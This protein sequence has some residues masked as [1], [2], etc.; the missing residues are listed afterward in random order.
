M[1]NYTALFDQGEGIQLTPHVGCAVHQL[2]PL[3][4]WLT[5]LSD[6]EWMDWEH[7]PLIRLH[8]LWE[9]RGVDLRMF[10]E[11]RRFYLAQCWEEHR[12]TC[13]F[14][15]VGTSTEWKY[16]SPFWFGCNITVPLPFLEVLTLIKWVQYQFRPFCQILSILQVGDY[17]PQEPLRHI[18][19]YNYS[20]CIDLVFA[21]YAVWPYLVG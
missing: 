14:G 10:Y 18:C 12:R 6:P 4:A 3:P 13:Y 11:E 7:H 9:V 19:G 20:S 2:W 15:R 5:L 8:F 1:L 16:A 17:S 21:K